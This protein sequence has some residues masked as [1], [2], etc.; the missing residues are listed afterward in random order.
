MELIDLTL[1]DC[2]IAGKYVLHSLRGIETGAGAIYVDVVQCGL[3]ARAIR[4][5]G[6]E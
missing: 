6:R 2:V 4:K 5:D 3:E 1:V